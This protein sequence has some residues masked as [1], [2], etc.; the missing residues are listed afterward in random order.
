M[1]SKNLT[2]AGLSKSA[3]PR[4]AISMPAS[5]PSTDVRG[6][7]YPCP[8]VDMPYASDELLDPLESDAFYN[9]REKEFVGEARQRG[10]VE[11]DGR[12]RRLGAGSMA[13]WSTRLALRMN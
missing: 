3:L 8:F 6:I 12:T 11:A 13:D 5:E 10:E 9:T 7:P 1:C 2:P 4:Y